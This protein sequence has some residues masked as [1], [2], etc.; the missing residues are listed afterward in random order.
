MKVTIFGTPKEFKGIYGVIQRNAIK[1]WLAAEATTPLLFGEDAGVSTIANELGIRHIETVRKNKLGTP[2]VNDLFRQ[3]TSVTDSEWSA[4]VNCDIILPPDYTQLIECVAKQI[5]KPFVFVSRRW[6]I[7]VDHEIDFSDPNWFQ[8]L[9]DRYANQRQLYGVNGMDL[10]V[11]P[12]GFY[13]AMPDFSIGWP[14]AKYDNWLVWYARNQNAAV[15]DITAAT[16]LFH[17]NHPKGG[18]AVHPEK[19]SEHMINLKHLGGYS[20]CY[21]IRDCTHRLTPEGVLEPI[22]FDFKTIPL[23]L[24]RIVQLL[25]DRVRFP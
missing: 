17:Q 6:D 10:F 24:K 7:D 4:Y 20:N 1:S 16:T 3:A 15:V 8:T 14:G 19:A 9:K 22:P 25:R 2:L 21:D 12:T 11:F 23:R 13:D 18:G 5:N